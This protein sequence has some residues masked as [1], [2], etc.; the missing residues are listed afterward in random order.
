[1]K[2]LAWLPIV[3]QRPLTAARTECRRP[4]HEKFIRP[5]GGGNQINTVTIWFL[6]IGSLLVLM[7]LMGSILQRLPLSPAM[8]YLAIGFALG[9]SGLGLLALDPKGNAPLFTLLSEIAV[10]ISLFAVGLRL[11][12]ELTDRIWWLAWRLGVG[13]M[14]ITIALLTGVGFYLLGL[15]LGAALLLAAILAPTDPVLASDVQIRNVGDRDRIRFSLSGEGGLN[16]G[17]TFP[18]VM[19]GL[20]L[21]GVQEAEPYGTPWG[22]AL[23]ATWGIAAGLASGWL[24]GRL[25]VGLVLHLR[26]N[27]HEALGMEEFLALGLI[28]LSYGVSHLIQ[29]IGFLAVFAAGVAMRRIE[30]RVSGQ[31]APAE[32][33]GAMGVGDEPVVATDPGKAPAYMAEVVLAFNQQLEHIVEFV[34]VLLLGVMLSATGFSMEGIVVAALLFVVVRPVSV[35]IALTGARANPLQRRLMAWFG[36]RGIGSLYYLMFAL[37]YQWQADLT[38]RFVSLVLTVLATSILVH[39]ISATPLMELYYRRRGMKGR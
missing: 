28:A 18:F 3:H 2:G 30:H 26:Q 33:I 25:V 10:L 19:L 7:G 36:I 32:V 34:M 22:L 15:P 4:I 14:L 13:A 12:V 9:P 39:G 11:R 21:L 20:F 6:I 29:G 24:M 16:D 23:H 38:Q 5:A 31:A 8:L 17:T 27:Y 1:M 37:Q 35:L